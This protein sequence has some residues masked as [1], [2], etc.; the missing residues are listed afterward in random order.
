MVHLINYEL[1]GVRLPAER[2]HVENAIKAL[3]PCYAFGPGTWLVESELTNRAICER[4]IP[5]LKRSDRI[6]A[7]RIHRDWV[8]ANVP[9]VEVDW[10]AA[11]NFTAATD[12]DPTVPR[13]PTVRG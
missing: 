4:I 5:L 8:M 1:V 2:S 9:Q 12:R 10:L 3:G 13:V 7:T 11:C 6:V